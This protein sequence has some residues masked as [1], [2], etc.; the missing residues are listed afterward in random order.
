MI[1]AKKKIL[2]KKQFQ[3]KSSY[4]LFL[5]ILS[6]ASNTIGATSHVRIQQNLL[7]IAFVI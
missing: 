5:A 4:R 7:T 2:V 6:L 3:T 1:T